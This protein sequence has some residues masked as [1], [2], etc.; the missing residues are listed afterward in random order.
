MWKKINKIMK[1]GR[2]TKVVNLVL[3]KKKRA[4]NNK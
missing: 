4:R 3:E 1:S 2:L